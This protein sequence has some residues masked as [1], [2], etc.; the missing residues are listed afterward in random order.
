VSGIGVVFNTRAGKNKNDP[1]A[2]TRLARQL[3]DHGIVAA[4]RS[5]DE[6]VRVAE[7][8]RA[9]KIEVLG[10]AGGDGTNH[11]TLTGFHKVYGAESLPTLSGDTYDGPAVTLP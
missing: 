10:I 11:V 1:G 8:F 9:Q 2:P 3:G 7:D 5:I 6:L 4:P